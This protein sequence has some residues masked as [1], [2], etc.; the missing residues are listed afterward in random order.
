[1]PFASVMVA[2][3]KGTHRFLRINGKADGSNGRGDLDTQ[4]LAAHLGVLTH[5]GEVK[6]VLLVQL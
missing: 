1:M 2:Q 6:K 3:Q 5:P 4:T